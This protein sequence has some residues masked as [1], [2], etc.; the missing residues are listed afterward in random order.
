MSAYFTFMEKALS[1][2][3]LQ[4]G[5]KQRKI[6][7]YLRV[8]SGLFVLL[9][10]VQCMVYICT[11]DRIGMEIA[12]AFTIGLFSIQACFK[13]A[14]IT[15]NFRKL[16]EIKK[17]IGE[18][19]EIL[20]V[21]ADPENIQKLNQ[22]R[23][24]T[25]LSLIT[26]VSCIWMFIFKPVIE[27]STAALTGGD[28]AKTLVFAFYYPSQ[29]FRVEFF[30]FTFLYETIV[31]HTMTIVPLACDGI[32]LLLVGQVSCIHKRIGDIF[33]KIIDEFEASKSAETDKKLKDTIEL[34]NRL[35][36]VGGGLMEIYEIALLTTA[37]LQTGTIC[38]I[39][40]IVSVSKV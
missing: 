36:N 37:L 16:S 27:L 18:L 9:S 30:Y 22:S 25:K 32:F 24:Y 4:F 19:M 7:K 35:Y 13:F 20:Q 26:N 8:F 15:F 12:N 31:G 17:S 39:A 28:V 21:E 11:A 40:F 33:K 5:D 10:S 1:T 14:A 2:L 38:F 6:D 23:K 29:K 3:G 34:H